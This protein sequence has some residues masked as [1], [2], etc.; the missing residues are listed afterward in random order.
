MEQQSPPADGGLGI[1]FGWR[2][3]WHTTIPLGAGRSDERHSQPEHFQS[4]IARP[5]LK[6]ALRT[7]LICIGKFHW[8]RLRIGGDFRLIIY[9]HRSTAYLL[10]KLRYILRSQS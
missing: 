6:F 10:V 2:G 5:R 8:Q 3:A 4:S 9:H 1:V 7:I